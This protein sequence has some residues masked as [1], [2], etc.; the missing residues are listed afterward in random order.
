M[1]P[2]SFIKS[3]PLQNINLC[4][5]EL[6]SLLP[7]FCQTAYFAHITAC[8][9]FQ[10]NVPCR[11]TNVLL[12]WSHWYTKLINLIPPESSKVCQQRTREKSFA[13][14][15]I[16]GGRTTP[17]QAVLLKL[18]WRPLHSPFLEEIREHK[19]LYMNILHSTLSLL[20][21][22]SAVKREISTGPWHNRVHFNSK[23]SRGG[24]QTKRGQSFQLSWHVITAPLECH[25][26]PSFHLQQ[27][28]HSIAII[29]QLT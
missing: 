26:T 5:N 10:F 29:M 12:S 28:T 3:Y 16:S 7:A 6:L 1:K 25:W 20:N 14:G 23:Q 13:G 4:T 21:L 18:I 11:R 2:R 22:N 9:L 17:L 19:R 8:Y 24:E 15:A 27:E